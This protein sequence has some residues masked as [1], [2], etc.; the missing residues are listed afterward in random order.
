MPVRGEC[1]TAINPK[2]PN[3]SPI[4]Q[5]TNCSNLP[6]AFVLVRPKLIFRRRD[7]IIRKSLVVDAVTVRVANLLVVGAIAFDRTFVD[8]LVGS[9]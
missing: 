3:K 4:R 5:F 2:R 8:V 6:L 7:R 9:R 1:R